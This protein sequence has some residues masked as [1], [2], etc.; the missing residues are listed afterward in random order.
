[1]IPPTDVDPDDAAKVTYRGAA[2]RRQS[3]EARYVPTPA[4]VVVS[5]EPTTESDDGMFAP[6]LRLRVKPSPRPT[7]VN[8]YWFNPPWIEENAA[9]DVHHGEFQ[10]PVWLAVEMTMHSERDQSLSNQ[11]PSRTGAGLHE[12]T[13]AGQLRSLLSLIAN[14]TRVATSYDHDRSRGRPVVPRQANASARYHE[15]P[16]AHASQARK[17]VRFIGSNVRKVSVNHN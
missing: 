10:T 3:S 12:R 16:L 14:S 4:L 8:K 1:V 9:P 6:P 13:H 15:L 5:D 2:K 7:P 17:F 11:N